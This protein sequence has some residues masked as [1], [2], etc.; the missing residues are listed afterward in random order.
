MRAVPADAVV[1][2]TLELASLEALRPARRRPAAE[3]VRARRPSPE[4]SRYLYTAV[5]G[6]WHWRDRLEW[7]WSRWL[8]VIGRRGYE[9]WYAVVQGTPAGY[10]E[11]N[12]MELPAARIEYFGL[13]PGCE[14]RGLGGWLLEQAVRRAFA[15]GATRVRVETCTLDGPAALPNYLARGFSIVETARRAPPSLPP[16]GPWPG[17]ARPKGA[18][19]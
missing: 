3:L 1:V 9:T 12:V 2:T 11:L 15:L 5:G 16:P 6:D 8:E 19:S 17:A 13:V 7:S 14:G 10:F 4:F 18:R